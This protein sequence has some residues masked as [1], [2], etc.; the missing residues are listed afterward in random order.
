MDLFLFDG[1]L[2]FD[3]SEYRNTFKTSILILY[4]IAIL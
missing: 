3:I 1:G 2:I 4:G